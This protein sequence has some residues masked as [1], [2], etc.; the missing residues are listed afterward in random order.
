MK[1]FKVTFNGRLNG[2]IG[3][4][5]PITE[6]IKADSVELAKLACYE[7]YELLSEFKILSEKYIL[8]ED[9]FDRVKS[10]IYGNPRYVIHFLRVLPDS[11]KR[12]DTLTIS[13]KYQFA[14]KIMN[15]IG[16]RKYSTKSYGGGIVFQSYSLESTIRDIE[17]LKAS[18]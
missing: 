13:A 5:Y 11:I 9:D 8:S 4:T 16:G 6:T 3:T 10:D 14:C 15:K 18:I 1:E 7:K 12:E 2:A 17:R